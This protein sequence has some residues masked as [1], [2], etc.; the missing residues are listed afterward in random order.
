MMYLELFVNKEGLLSTRFKTLSGVL[1]YM[2]YIEAKYFEQEP[3]Q[4][5]FDFSGVLYFGWRNQPSS[6]TMRVYIGLL[7]CTFI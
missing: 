4:R 6:G 3:V 7:L 1:P 5:I 2:G